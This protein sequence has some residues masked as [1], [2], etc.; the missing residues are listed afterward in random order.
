[1]KPIFLSSIFLSCLLAGCCQRPG[2]A[3]APTPLPPPYYYY[4]PTVPPPALRQ[5]PPL[6]LPPA[7]R[8][9]NYRGGS[10]LWAA[11]QDVLL[12]GGREEAAARCRAQ[13][14][15]GAAASEVEEWAAASQIPLI[16]TRDGDADFLDWCADTRRGAAVYWI[17]GGPHVCRKCGKVHA[18][19]ALTFC[20]FVAGEAVL[21]DS[22]RPGQLI[23]MPREK[24][25]ADWR[26][27]GG[28]AL[29]LADRHPAP[30]RP[31]I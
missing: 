19:H 7:M 10:C 8:Q 25:L 20:G 3:T 12:W 5:V 16:T 11:M 15:G 1:M 18:D 27:A 26:A 9:G 6:D 2:P 4:Q 13:C 31:W 23:R 30:P 17:A 21:I 28:V 24:F 29:T 22:N 14:S